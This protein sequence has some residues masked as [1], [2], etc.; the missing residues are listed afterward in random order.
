LK[1]I[2]PKVN[3]RKTGSISRLAYND[4]VEDLFGRAIGEGIKSFRILWD[5]FCRINM[6]FK[7]R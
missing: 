5:L 2:A 7:C 3:R 6:A 1:R 4:S